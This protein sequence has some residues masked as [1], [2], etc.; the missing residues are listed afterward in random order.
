MYRKAVGGLCGEIIEGIYR[1]SYPGLSWVLVGVVCGV[2]IGVLIGVVSGVVC[3][4]ESG[5]LVGVVTGVSPTLVSG[6][7][8]DG[9]RSD[10]YSESGIRI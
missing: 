1:D 8:S 5:V 7:I 10:D 6:L 3:G 2:L 4:V 9:T